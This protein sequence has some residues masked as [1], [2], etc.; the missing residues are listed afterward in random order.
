MCK[1]L[2]PDQTRIPHRTIFKYL[3][4][5]VTSI[6]SASYHLFRNLKSFIATEYPIN[7]THIKNEMQMHF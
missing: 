3:F 4:V 5:W 1:R 2:V 6:L 7:K